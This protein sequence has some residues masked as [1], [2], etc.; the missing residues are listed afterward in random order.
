MTFKVS[1]VIPT[2]NRPQQ[3]YTAID[4]VLSQSIKPDEIIVVNDGASFDGFDDLSL[5]GVKTVQNSRPMGGNYSRHKGV[6]LSTGDIVMFLDD[7]DSWKSDKVERQ[8][9][10]FH[11]NP[12]IGLVYCNRNVVDEEGMLQRKITS[13]RQGYLYPDIYFSNIIGTTS[14]VAI[15]RTVYDQAGG[16]DP[17]M[18]A[19]Q[20]YDLWIRAVRFTRVGLV[21]EHVIDY[22]VARDVG[23]QVSKSGDKQ[24]RAVELMTEKYKTD[25]ER[26]ST[27]QRRKAIAAFNFYVAKSYRGK[28]VKEFLYYVSRSIQ[29]FPSV[30]AFALLLPDSILKK[31][32]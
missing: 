6:E 12:E 27:V 19:L 3:L 31:I 13:S 1:V 16:F 32:T 15:K 8:M 7:D 10:L 22:T 4:S 14:S 21:D 5:K 28:S 11:S 29:S 2:F 25:I 23:K 26:L 18:P 24:K 17:V 30:R 20:D 9:S